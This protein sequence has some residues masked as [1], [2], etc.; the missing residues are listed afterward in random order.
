MHFFF[1]FLL[2]KFSTKDNTKNSTIDNDKYTCFTKLYTYDQTIMFNVASHII[3]LYIY[4]YTYRN[5]S[6]GPWINAQN[7]NVSPYI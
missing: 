3:N 6:E 1:L 4:I 5:I 7:Q 2:T